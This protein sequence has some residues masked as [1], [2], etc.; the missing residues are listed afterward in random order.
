MHSNHDELDVSKEIV[1]AYDWGFCQI[2][3]NREANAAA[4]ARQGSERG[5][6]DD[7]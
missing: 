4:S 2:Q 7:G 1:D 3:Y 6:G 5:E